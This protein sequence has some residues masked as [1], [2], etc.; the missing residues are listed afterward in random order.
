MD[1]FNKL[2]QWSLQAHSCPCFSDWQS[3]S[4]G[5]FLLDNSFSNRLS[6]QTPQGEMKPG[7]WTLLFRL[8]RGS[9]CFYVNNLRLMALLPTH[10]SAVY[11]AADRTTLMANLSPSR[12]CLLLLRR[13]G[14]EGALC[15]S[16]CDDDHRLL[17]AHV[18]YLFFQKLLVTDSLTQLRFVT[19]ACSFVSPQVAFTTRIYHPNINSN[20]SICLDIL[21]SQWSP[22]LTISKGMSCGLSATFPD[23]QMAFGLFPVVM[24]TAKLLTHISKCVG[25]WCTL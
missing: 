16:G 25:L 8:F 2:C 18:P 17:K 21:R 14:K 5:S 4:G 19:I 3:I 22:A 20:G 7:I 11:D 13:G 23:Y 15:F 24:V 6:F 12:N 10:R 1:D 9:N